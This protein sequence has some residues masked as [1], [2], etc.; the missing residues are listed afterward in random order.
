VNIDQNISFNVIDE[1]ISCLATV[2]EGIALFRANS[3]NLPAL[4]AATR[5]AQSIK[6]AASMIDQ[7]DIYELAKRLETEL[8][9]CPGGEITEDMERQFAAQL[10][11]LEL[12]LLKKKASL[13]RA[14][15]IAAETTLSPPESAVALN[16]NSFRTEEEDF[17]A[18]PETLEI[19]SLEADDLLRNIADQLKILG[20]APGSFDALMEVRRSAHTLKGSAAIIG[21]KPLSSLAHR[22]EDLLDFVTEYKLELSA[23]VH[24]LLSASADCLAA[25]AHGETREELQSVI[26]DLYLRYN[27]T[28]TLLEDGKTSSVP[29]E[30]EGA[31]PALLAALAEENKD[32]GEILTGEEKHHR[33]S[34]IRISIE[35]LDELMRLFSEVLQ[36]RATIEQRLADMEKQVQELQHSTGRLRQASGKLEIDF[37]AGMMK[38][39]A[40]RGIPSASA[41]AFN[42]AGKPQEFDELEFDRYTEFHQVTRQLVETGSDVASI[43]IE[44]ESLLTNLESVFGGQRHL[45]DEIQKRLMQ[46]R[47]VA[48]DSLGRRLQRT[49]RITAEQE[50]KFVDLAIEGGELEVDTQILDSL[51][52]PLL[53]ILRNAV[54]HGIEAPDTRKLLGK[55]EQ[56]VI[57]LRLSQEGTFVVL[58]VSDDGRGVQLSD[59]RDKALKNHFVTETQ[60]A[61]M[62]E[63]EILSLVFLPGL[64]TS[65]E[66]S[67]VS[68]RG[69]GMNIVKESLSRYQGTVSVSSELQ[70]GTTFTLR[71]PMAL[72][73]MR[74]LLVKAGS[75]TYAIPLNLV[76]QVIEIS[77]QELEKAKAENLL[78]VNNHSYNLTYLDNLLSF[79]ELQRKE[80]SNVSVLLLKT[81]EEDRALVVDELLP[82]QE[83]VLKPLCFPLQNSPGF[84]GASILGNGKVVPVL[85]LVHLLKQTKRISAPLSKPKIKANASVMIV[86]DS[87]SVRRIMS[88]VISSAGWEVKAAKDG[89]EAFEML[90]NDG[91]LPKVI[92]TDVEMPRMDGYELLATLKRHDTFRQIPVIIIT[93]RAGEKHRRKALDLG[94]SEYVTKPYEDSVLTEII[95][96]LATS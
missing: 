28:M 87:P 47:M 58:S 90:Q 20:R 22:M 21:M 81:S 79:P 14:E 5:D 38:T 96:R 29:P 52:E 63:E 57:T 36:S 18:D 62:T 39:G 51:I 94:V 43:N 40:L 6:G 82:P 37:E 80:N 19:F 75:E 55:S 53:H 54:S 45:I 17:E 4:Q 11:E 60:L 27:V 3:N 66:V 32:E 83:I 70:R 26:A 13:A 2:Q 84:L 41:P 15:S 50:E 33:N 86:D 65:T 76:K 67:E 12:L 71:V 34:I 31:E 61:A 77:A 23:D 7:T 8:R 46:F 16:G 78:S 25:L 35:R 64:S 1:A 49:V 30:A 24:L 95:K 69:V 56:G 92:L 48:F 9:K 73:A 89:M 91:E 59:L 44:M 88:A 72:S 85:D 93:S 74:A 10:D 42:A 68:G